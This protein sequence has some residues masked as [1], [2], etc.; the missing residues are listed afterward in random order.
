MRN[1]LLVCLLS[2]FLMVCQC[3]PVFSATYKEETHVL[4]TTLA[5][6]RS[7]LLSQDKATQLALLGLKNPFT[8]QLPNWRGDKRTIIELIRDGTVLE[9]I[10]PRSN[11]HFFN[12]RTGESVLSPIPNYPSPAWILEDQIDIPNQEFSYAVARKSFLKGIISEKENDRKIALGIMFQS[13]G[14]VLHHIQDMA[15]PQHSRV[16]SHLDIDKGT[17]INALL[18]GFGALRPSQLEYYTNE[19]YYYGN[20]WDVN[21]NFIAGNSALADDIENAAAALNAD[22][23][24]EN[25]GNGISIEEIGRAHV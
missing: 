22:L 20:Y 18:T 14:N 1:K 9:D 23:L 10:Y 7:T 3:I 11:H 2:F 12:P 21:Q 24:K 19:K 4:L 8:D 16:D 5:V 17:L 25:Y 13:L 15:Q 6:R